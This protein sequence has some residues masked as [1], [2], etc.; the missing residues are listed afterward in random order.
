MRQ[1]QSVLRLSICVFILA[2]FLGCAVS[3]SNTKNTSTP[4]E[5]FSPGVNVVYYPTL[6]SGET[7]DSVK[8]DLVRILTTGYVYGR[9][10]NKG[11]LPWR[12]IQTCSVLDDLI[13][14]QTQASR[15]SFRFDDLIESHVV[16]IEIERNLS[17]QRINLSVNSLVF[18]FSKNALEDA[19]RAADDLLFMQTFIKQH[20]ER[21]ALFESKAT[22]Y[23]A[24][25]VKP[26]M[27]EE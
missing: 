13:E 14:I 20:D 24:L 19:Q 21:L 7:F 23:R 18:L 4:I 3:E 9:D 22:E 11:N 27:S 26:P 10:P 15:F 5:S 16:V 6:Q 17:T 25:K 2:V 1:I 12:Y 8:N